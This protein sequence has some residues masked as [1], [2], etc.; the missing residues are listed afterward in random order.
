MKEYRIQAVSPGVLVPNEQSQIHIT[1][2]MSAEDRGGGGGAGAGE[3][4]AGSRELG[5]LRLPEALAPT[6][7]R[8]DLCPAGG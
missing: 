6:Q 5:W 3:R 2:H 8:S 7:T 1:D 4:P